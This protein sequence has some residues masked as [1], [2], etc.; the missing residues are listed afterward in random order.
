MNYL[1]GHQKP[2]VKTLRDKF[3]RMIRLRNS[4]NREDNSASG[5]LEFYREK[6]QLFDDFLLEK[7]EKE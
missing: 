6:Y 5:I 4:K 1:V 3:R 7:Y 2:S